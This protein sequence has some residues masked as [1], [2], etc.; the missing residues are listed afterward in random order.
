MRKVIS[1]NGKWKMKYFDSGKDVDKLLKDKSE[2]FI[3][4]EVPGVNYLDLIRLNKIEE[5]F[6]GKNFKKSQWVYEKDWLYRKEFSLS[7]GLIIKNKKI[8]L[9]FEGMDTFADIYLNKKKILSTNDMFIPYEINITNLVETEN[10]LDVQIHSPLKILKM[11]GI[12]ELKGLLYGARAFLGGCYNIW[13]M[14]IK[15]FIKAI[16]DQNKFEKLLIDEEEKDKKLTFK[17]FVKKFADNFL[18]RVFA[19]KYQISYGWDICIPKFLPSGIYKDVEIHISDNLTIKE[20]FIKANK[21]KKEKAEI[22][23]EAEIEN[24][25]DETIDAELKFLIRNQD[26]EIINTQNI[27]NLSGNNKF[28]F[29]FEIKNPNLWYPHTIGEPNLYELEM[30]LKVSGEIFDVKKTSFGIRKVELIEKDEYGNNV[31]IFKINDKKIFAKGANWV[32]LDILVPRI[33]SEKYTKILQM[34]KSAN[35]NMLRIHGGGIIENDIFYD[36]CDKMGIM[37]W[38]DFMF[39]CGLYP[40]NKKFLTLVKEETEQIVKKLRNHPSILLWCGDNENDMACHKNGHPINRKIIPEVLNKFDTTRPYIRS[41]PSGG[42][43]P[44]DPSEGDRH[45]WTVWHGQKPYRTFAEDP[46]PFASEFGLIAYPKE[47]IL[48]KFIPED[49]LWPQNSYHLT[50]C[51]VPFKEKAM[52]EEYGDADNIGDYTYLTQIAQ[53]FGLKYALEHYRRRK[54]KCAGSLVWQLNDV[55]PGITW[56]LI[57][58]YLNPKISYYLVKKAFSPVLIS[59][60]EEKDKVS[61]WVTSDE[62]K[63]L[64]GVIDVFYQD[65]KG[66]IYWKKNLNI[67]IEPDSSKKILEISFKDLP[68]FEKNKERTF[69]FAKMNYNGKNIENYYFFSCFKDIKLPPAKISIKEFNS[70]NENYYSLKLKTDNLARIVEIEDSEDSEINLSDNYF[71]I[72]PDGEKEIIVEKITELPLKL[73][74]KGINTNLVEV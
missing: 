51:S 60:S 25:S 17:D 30:Q 14:G 62:Q 45:N 19:R 31:F 11:E 37:L 57:D 34:V 12:S 18:I 36:L 38:H 10:I 50:H 16:K 7:E 53:G 52:L 63:E 66:E 29:N 61:L 24:L 46:T 15:E 56:S 22:S 23:V 32:P 43:Y 69:L 73:S 35:M 64:K 55:W 1:L 54:Y 58:Y 49:K 9:K 70:I 41:S 13:A 6:Y 8:I 67:S 65:F 2:N 21:I 48:K 40:D 59:F 20:I 71:E 47:K 27:K 39:A 44:N 68:D 74:I 72:P 3:D 26:N 4:A 28:I 42:K 5:P 33:T